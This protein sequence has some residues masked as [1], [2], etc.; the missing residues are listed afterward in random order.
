MCLL[1]AALATSILTTGCQYIQPAQN[2]SQPAQ[3]EKAI[4]NKWEAETHRAHKEINQRPP[5]EQ[6]EYHDW[7]QQHS[8][9]H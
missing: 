5:E 6:K 1:V 8:K 7:N 4:Y 3:D 2:N 9:T